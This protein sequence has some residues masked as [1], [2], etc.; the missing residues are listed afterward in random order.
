V[1]ERGGEKKHIAKGERKGV[2][3]GD[4]LHKALTPAK[5]AEKGVLVDVVLK[6]LVTK[7]PLKLGN[8]LSSLVPSI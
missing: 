3:V 1:S 4:L 8:R 2:G 6:A 7:T 5:K